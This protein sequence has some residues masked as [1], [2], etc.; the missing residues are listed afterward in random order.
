VSSGDGY[1]SD[2]LDGFFEN[3]EMDK[4]KT[5]TEA[6]MMQPL[7]LAYIGDAIFELFIRN[8]LINRKDGHVNE[9]HRQSTCYVKAGAQSKIIHALEPELTEEEWTI[10]KR[11][12]NQK[13]AT[14]PKHADLIEYKYATGFEAL[15]GY[16]FY[17]GDYE[18]LI[19]IMNRA[20]EIIGGGGN[21]T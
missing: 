6:G 2:I 21:I 1:R 17:I 12:R 16:L 7:V 15:L 19:A 3:I 13:S 5:K 10:V 11:G 4:P 18:R 8:Y 20:T 14:V 9:Y